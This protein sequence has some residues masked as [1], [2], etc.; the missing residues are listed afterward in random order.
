MQSKGEVQTA[1][2]APFSINNRQM[3]VNCEHWEIIKGMMGLC[4]WCQNEYYKKHG[5]K[6]HSSDSNDVESP[7]S[8]TQSPV[9]LRGG[10]SQQQ[11]RPQNETPLPD[12]R[13]FSQEGQRWTF[14][15]DSEEMETI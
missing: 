5:K 3:C 12:S 6:S 1:V 10:N 14:S 8:P 15:S 11:Q 13:E 4:D 7:Q 2:V 9:V